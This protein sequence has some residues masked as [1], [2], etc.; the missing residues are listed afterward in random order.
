M[1]KENQPRNRS[2]RSIYHANMSKAACVVMYSRTH[3]FLGISGATENGPALLLRAK[4][5]LGVL[6]LNNSTNSTTANSSY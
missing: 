1:R 5:F 2:D 3:V 6:V 4:A